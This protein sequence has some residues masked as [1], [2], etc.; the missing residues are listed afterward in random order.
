MK[1][2]SGEMPWAPTDIV[3]RRK[4]DLLLAEYNLKGLSEEQIRSFNRVWHRLKPW[5][6]SVGGLTRLKK[7]FIVAPFF[8]GDFN[9]L[10][11]SVKTAGLPWDCVL[12]GDMFKKFK[13]NLEIYKDAVVLLGMEPGETM[14]VAAHPWD[15]EMA[16]KVGMHTAYVHRPLEF[17]PQA[18]KENVSTTSFDFI[19]SDFNELATVLGA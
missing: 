15:L 13:P 1:V 16:S 3:H 8:N 12:S 7:K 10:V 14:M 4:L 5:A 6:D 18:T 9:L 11:N 19:V 2:A 17:G